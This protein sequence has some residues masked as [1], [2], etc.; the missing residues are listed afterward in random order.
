MWKDLTEVV[1]FLKNFLFGERIVGNEWDEGFKE[2]G[3]VPM[4]ESV[5]M[6]ATSWMTNL[7]KRHVVAMAKK[8]T[9]SMHGRQTLLNM[10]SHGNMRWVLVHVID[11]R[12]YHS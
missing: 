5:R 8:K 11:T 9:S 4:A 10:C 2:P 3:A 7:S 1:C 6:P 12:R